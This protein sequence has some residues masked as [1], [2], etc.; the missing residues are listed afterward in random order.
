MSRALLLL[1]VAAGPSGIPTLGPGG[2]QSEP[3]VLHVLNP[4][5]SPPR[6]KHPPIS[7]EV[8]AFARPS[9]ETSVLSQSHHPSAKDPATQEAEQPRGRDG[10]SG[11]AHRSAW[12]PRHGRRAGNQETGLTGKGWRGDTA[13]ASAG[14][15]AGG[16]AVWTDNVR[17]T[18]TPSDPETPL[19]A[20]CPPDALGPVIRVA[21]SNSQTQQTRPQH[22][23]GQTHH[24]TKREVRSGCGTGSPRT[25]QGPEWEQNSF[26]FLNSR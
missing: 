10:P 16:P 1:P 24:G 19:P 23:A 8:P 7:K 15:R 6:P 20:P 22:R 2:G 12:L 14:A 4:S 9:P 11:R 3:L 17:R 5:H 25:S 18:H 26:T 21:H 13:A